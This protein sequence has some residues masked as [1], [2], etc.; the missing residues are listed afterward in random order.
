MH[1]L[2]LLL[3]VEARLEIFARLGGGSGMTVPDN[4]FPLALFALLV[5]F[6]GFAR[7]LVHFVS[8][9]IGTCGC[10]IAERGRNVGAGI[11]RVMLL[12]PCLQLTFLLFPS[13]VEELDSDVLGEFVLGNG[14][15]TVG[16]FGS[17]DHDIAIDAYFL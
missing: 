12:L 14:L 5:L 8:K 10:E 7:R 1:V 6:L 15:A 4:L 11:D 13:R 16:T 9:Q 3:H 2:D 17:V